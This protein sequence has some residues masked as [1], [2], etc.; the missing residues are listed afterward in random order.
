MDI[1]NDAS[2]R[3]FFATNDVFKCCVTLSGVEDPLTPLRVT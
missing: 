1:R 2:S 3:N